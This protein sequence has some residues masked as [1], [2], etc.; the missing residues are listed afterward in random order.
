[1]NATPESLAYAVFNDDTSAAITM[2]IAA[3][4][5]EERAAFEAAYDQ[6]LAEADPNTEW[7]T[8]PFDELGIKQ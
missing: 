8:Q 3:L 4:S 5:K 1:M 2:S 6:L 7:Y